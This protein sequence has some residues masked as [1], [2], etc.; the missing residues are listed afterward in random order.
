MEKMP[1]ILLLEDETLLRGALA[2]A[3]GT[4]G[5]RIMAAGS[6]ETGETLL[7][8]LGWQW[9]D[10]VICDAD[11]SREPGAALGHAF[12]ARWR[13]RFPVPPFIFMHAGTDFTA[14][15][16]DGDCRVC[17][18]LKP[19]APGELLLLIRAVLAN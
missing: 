12:H 15:V 11:M 10:L 17:H 16:R 13:A 6:P 2:M 8:I 4:Q 7:R 19:F 3:L 18:I 14:F 1:R 9:M 5:Y